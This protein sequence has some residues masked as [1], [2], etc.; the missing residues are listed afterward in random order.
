MSA[1]QPI[2]FGVPTCRRY[3]PSA[4]GRRYVSSIAA[5]LAVSVVP[6]QLTKMRSRTTFS[7]KLPN[8]NFAKIW[9]EFDITYQQYQP[10][11]KANKRIRKQ[12]IYS[13][14]SIVC[15]HNP[16]ITNATLIIFD[17]HLNVHSN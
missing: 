3:K 7:S 4:L 8:Y 15:C 9:K 6:I 14:L 5:P 11:D 1:P 16:I 12:F 10:K 2:D 13:Y 17:V